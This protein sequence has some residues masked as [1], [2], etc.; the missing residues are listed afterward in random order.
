MV[1]KSCKFDKYGMIYYKTTDKHL[2]ASNFNGKADRIY[3][4]YF[5]SI[6]NYYLI[7]TISLI[8]MLIFCENRYK[9]V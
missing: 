3:Y 8:D 7:S 9:N 6:A 1:Y 4:Q 5:V 2:T